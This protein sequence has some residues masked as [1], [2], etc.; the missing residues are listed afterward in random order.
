MYDALS[1]ERRKLTEYTVIG[2]VIRVLPKYET[3]ALT[4]S[5]NREWYQEHI[6]RWVN[7]VRDN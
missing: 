6:W 2:L 7:I 3:L 5:K 4:T 1:Y